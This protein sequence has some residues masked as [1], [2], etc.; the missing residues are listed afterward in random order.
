MSSKITD[1]PETQEKIDR[2][3][4]KITQRGMAVPAILT[5]ASR[6]AW[7]ANMCTPSG[8]DSINAAGALASNAGMPTANPNW[9]TPSQ[10]RDVTPASFSKTECNF[11]LGEDRC[12]ESV[13]STSGNTIVCGVAYVHYIGPTSNKKDY[14][15]VAGFDLWSGGSNKTYEFVT[16]DICCSG[17]IIFVNQLLGFGSTTQTI[18]DT[19]ALEDLTAYQLANKL[20]NCASPEWLI[21]DAIMNSTSLSDIQQFYASCVG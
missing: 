9:R 20:N 12:T 5:L 8:F 7:G 21:P 6:S 16:T 18:Y 1:I 11:A 14:Q 15:E 17:L 10:W 4:R 3:K 13:K 19:L 2:S